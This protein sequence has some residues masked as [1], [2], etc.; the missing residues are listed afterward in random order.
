MTSYRMLL[1][2]GAVAGPLYVL[3]AVAQALTR[4][5]FD[6]TRHPVSLLSNGELGWIQILNF[7]IAG[8]LVVASAFGL[9]AAQITQ[10]GSFW[11]PVLIGVFGAGLIASGIFVADPA[12][13]FPPGTPAGDPSTVSFAGI[14]HFMVGGVSFICLIAACLIYAR[15]FAVRHMLGLATISALTGAFYLGAFAMIASAPGTASTLLFTAAVVIGWAW[16]SAVNIQALREVAPS[17][18]HVAQPA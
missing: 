15:G 18:H 5:G 13:G 17:S 4:E 7:V 8:S 2:C 12:D 11:G 3:V 1:I 14:M 6:S 16:L 10:H 9:R